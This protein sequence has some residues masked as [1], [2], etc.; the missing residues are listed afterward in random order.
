MSSAYKRRIIKRMSEKARTRAINGWVVRHAE[1]ATRPL[2]EEEEWERARRKDVLMKIV[3]ITDPRTG[4]TN[5]L[6]IW[7]GRGAAVNQVSVMA[8]G[9]PWKTLGR[10]RLAESLARFLA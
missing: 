10:T 6:Q 1:M 9:K 8:N 4:E 7:N 3:T 2:S 5:R